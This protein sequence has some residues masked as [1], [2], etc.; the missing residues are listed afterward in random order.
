[1]IDTSPAITTR[2]GSGAPE[3]WIRSTESAMGS[4]A[5]SY[6]WWLAE[7]NDGELDG[8]PLATLAP[9]GER[10][11][12]GLTARWRLDGDRLCFYAEPDGG[13]T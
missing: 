11:A 3:V 13:D 5:P 9:P 4:L 1:M 7:Y 12:D 10:D 2:P 8:E 6:R